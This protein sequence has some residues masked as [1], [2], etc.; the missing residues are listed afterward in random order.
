MD[1]RSRNKMYNQKGEKLN[2][3]F[4]LHTSGHWR[5]LEQRKVERTGIIGI[6][7]ILVNSDLELQVNCSI[8]EI[9]ALLKQIRVMAVDTRKFWIK[10]FR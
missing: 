8:D 10:R 3:T 9:Q 6:K 5:S 1:S 4:F 7:F 2:I